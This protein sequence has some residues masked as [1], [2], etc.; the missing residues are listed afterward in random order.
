MRVSVITVQ[1]EFFIHKLMCNLV[2]VLR[3]ISQHQHEN[4]LYTF[5]FKTTRNPSDGWPQCK[6]LEVFQMLWE[7]IT[8]QKHL[9]HG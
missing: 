5:I 7:K 2:K 4:E 6:E 1:K 8:A 9:A 3:L